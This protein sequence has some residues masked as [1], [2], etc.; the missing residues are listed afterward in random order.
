ML[1]G[2]LAQPEVAAWWRVPDHQ[3][4]LIRE[5]LGH[6]VM[7]QVIACRADVPLGYAQYYPARH[8][9]APHFADLPED[10]IAIDVF[11]APAGRGHGGAWLRELGDLLL[12]EASTLAIDPASD[13]HRAIRAYEKAGFAGD[14]V[15]TDSEG[16]PVR[17][18]TRRR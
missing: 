17:V 13:N 6:L 8:W 7:R 10:S 16:Q 11:G 18:M 5:D 15:R 2:W 1:A 12:R 3:I 4:R 9:P 14:L